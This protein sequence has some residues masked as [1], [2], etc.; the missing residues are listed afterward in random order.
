MMPGLSLE[1]AVTSVI[2]LNPSRPLIDKKDY[3][4]AS[5]SNGLE[6]LLISTNGRRDRAAASMTV[7]VGSFSDPADVEVHLSIY[8][9][10]HVSLKELF[11]A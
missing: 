6:V 1:T 10:L 3:K 8:I 11:C 7:N 2:D 9:Y 4:L 5:F